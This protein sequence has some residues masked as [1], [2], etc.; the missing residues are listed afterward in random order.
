MNMVKYYFE[1]II[2]D[3]MIKDDLE[4][5]LIT[6][7]RKD[8]LIRTLEQVFNDKSPIKEFQFTILDN[9]SDDGSSEVIEEYCKKHKNI[10]HIIHPHNIGGNANIARAF[11]IAEKKYVWII[12]DDDYYN[13]D[14]WHY[15]EDAVNNEN[16][17]CILVARDQIRNTN[18]ISDLIFQS[19]FLP[20]GIYKTSAIDDTVYRNMYDN[21]PNMFPHL[22]VSANIANTTKS[23]CV[24]PENVLING[25][26]RDKKEGKQT[27]DMSYIRNTDKKRLS[28][29]A[30]NMHFFIGYVN[31]L[32][33]LHDK[34]AVMNGLRSA[35]A[36]KPFNMSMT[37]V[38]A[39]IVQKSYKDKKSSHLY[40]EV[41]CRVD[42][43][44]KCI[45]TFFKY[46]PIFFYVTPK[47]IHVQILNT[48]VIRLIPFKLRNK[49]I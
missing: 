22:A 12:C 28:P 47:G 19:T 23:F 11:E 1:I 44:S 24:I 42:F 5:I 35:V 32:T 48:L 29:T 26:E 46:S 43:I 38:F 37:G 9:H 30:Q 13:W 21:I 39:R 3:V 14:N 4:I 36:Y 49:S 33:L 8:F 45:L 41:A 40:Y 34:N 31:S 25:P 7:N 17:D 27:A 6:Y 18:N 10:K 2:G 15:V 16:Y 20:S